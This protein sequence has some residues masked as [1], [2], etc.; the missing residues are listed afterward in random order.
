MRGYTTLSSS[1]VCIF[2][3]TNQLSQVEIVSINKLVYIKATENNSRVIKNMQKK[4]T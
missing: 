4:L 1:I 2:T 3:V